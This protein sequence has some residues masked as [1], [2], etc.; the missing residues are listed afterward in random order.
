M[1]NAL[2][3]EKPVCAIRR[4]L[5][6]P[7][8]CW[9]CWQEFLSCLLQLLGILRNAD[10]HADSELMP[11]QHVCL[12]DLDPGMVEGTLKPI[13]HMSDKRPTT[14]SCWTVWIV[15]SLVERDTNSKHKYQTYR[16]KFLHMKLGLAQLFSKAISWQSIYWDALKV[17][18][19][20]R[21]KTRDVGGPVNVSQC[22][23]RPLIKSLHQRQLKQISHHWSRRNLQLQKWVCKTK[24]GIQ[25]WVSAVV[26]G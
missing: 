16:T 10:G 21:P 13:E 24:S 7:K 18:E 1:Q 4:A 15:F 19:K 11:V 8:M 26:E 22:F 25:Q 5:F 17:S 9:R 23:K 20:S 6:L 3:W 12:E 2:L 14:S